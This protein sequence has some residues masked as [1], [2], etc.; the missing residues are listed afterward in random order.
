MTKRGCCS[1]FPLCPEPNDLQL[2][3]SSTEVARGLQRTLWP[4][5]QICQLP[6]PL[7]TLSREQ[8]QWL[9]QPLQVEPQLHRALSGESAR[10]RVQAS[11]HL[12]PP[13]HLL[14]QRVQVDREFGCAEAMRKL[15][16]SI[17]ETLTA[18]QV[19]VPMKSMSEAQIC[20]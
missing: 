1:P 15:W 2:S 14:S 7:C 10:V 5:T 19:W 13:G 3:K 8:S 11:P 17:S 12:L 20:V 18:S 4:L 16:S 6:N 9:L